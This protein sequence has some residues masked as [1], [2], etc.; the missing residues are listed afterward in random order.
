MLFICS[1]F[2]NT[3]IGSVLDRQP[4]EQ[5]ISRPILLLTRVQALRQYKSYSH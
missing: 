2:A 4:E 3:Y 1:I 5:K